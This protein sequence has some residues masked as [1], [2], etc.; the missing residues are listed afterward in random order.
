MGA[1]VEHGYT[2]TLYI[3]LLKTRIK[4]RY[5]RTFISYL[6]EKRVCFHYKDQSVNVAG[7]WENNCYN[8]PNTCP[9]NT[10]IC[11]YESLEINYTFGLRLSQHHALY[12][13][14]KRET[15]QQ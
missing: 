2:T 15:L 7:L 13:N 11:I 8:T 12:A 3:N 10:T 1:D 4:L 9:S 5:R 6:T 14:K